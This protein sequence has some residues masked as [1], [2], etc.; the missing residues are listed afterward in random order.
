MKKAK[1]ISKY[2]VD[3]I[4]QNNIDNSVKE[5]WNSNEN[6]INLKKYLNIHG[7]NS[8]PKNTNKPK[9]GKTA[10]LFFC[11]DFRDSVKKEF[12]TYSARE[13]VVVL[14][15]RWN[16]LKI[17]NPK[18]ISIYEKK[19]VLERAQYK[20]DMSIYK[21]Q[22]GIQVVEKEIKERKT[23]QKKV[24]EEN[25]KVEPV[26]EEKIIKNK[27]EVVIHE[28]DNHE[29]DNHEDENHED[30][31]NEIVKSVEI[32]KP[33]PKKDDDYGFEKYFKKKVK[34][35]KIA[36]PELDESQ[37]LKKLKKKWKLLSDDKKNDYRD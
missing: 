22:N 16:D 20:H 26:K 10:Y 11:E 30:E 29:D 24:K 35:T 6:L 4:E 28:D 23:R 25:I 32:S 9:R 21:K 12:P 19:S 17:K 8:K 14:G 3:F 34:K 27:D 5:K 1:N 2:I 31:D 36:H 15:E 7:F 37:I 33:S 13:I 18:K